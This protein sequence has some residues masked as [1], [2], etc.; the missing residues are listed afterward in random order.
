MIVSIEQQESLP[1]NCEPSVYY[2][3]YNT[4]CDLE[5]ED[6]VLAFVR[7]GGRHL[8]VNARKVAGSHVAMTATRLT[9][10]LYKLQKQQ[11][12]Q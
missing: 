7:L 4:P 3:Y 9:Q 8:T 11:Q 12:H 2:Y 1:K 6:R 5:P 10:R